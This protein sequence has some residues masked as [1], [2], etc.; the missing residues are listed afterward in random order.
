[1]R[2][3]SFAGTNGVARLGALSDKGLVDLRAA[4]RN[5][6]VASD[7]F[8]DMIS[9]L[10]GGETAANEAQRLIQELPHGSVVAAAGI[11]LLP[12][13]PRPGKIIAIG[14]N[15]RDHQIE[16]GAKEAPKSPMIFAKFPTSIAAAEDPIVIPVG[17][18]QVDYEAEMAVV[19]GKKGKAIPEA[20]ALEYVAGYMPLNDVSARA[21]QFS[22]KQW[23]RGKSCDTFCPT[24]PYL[25]TKDEIPDPH[26]LTIQARVNGT[27]LQDSNTSKMIFQVPQ[28]IAHISASITLE[29]GDII[30]TGT[31]EGVGAFRNPPIYL[32]PGDVVE[33]EIEKL[34]ILRNPVVATS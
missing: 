13:V 6:G 34:G 31:P 19:I 29:P 23:V 7:A 12:P 15:Y 24:G 20:K 28:L 22:D 30:A 25:T 26:G 9:F 2:V 5:L 8:A 3:A 16:S 18:P 17:D 11:R 21:W 1:M 33:I 27:T 14:L 10:A 32:K 4:A